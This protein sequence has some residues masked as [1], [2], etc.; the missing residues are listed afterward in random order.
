MIDPYI[1]YLIDL[2][3]DKDQELERL[4]EELENARADLE[5]KTI[6]KQ[7]ESDFYE[8]QRRAYRE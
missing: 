5:I 8:Y 1:S 4:R 3:K 2:I 7:Q 6:E